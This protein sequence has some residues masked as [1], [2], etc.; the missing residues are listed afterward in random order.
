VLGVAGRLRDPALVACRAHL[1]VHWMVSNNDV[2]G[3]L[4]ENSAHTEGISA[5]HESKVTKD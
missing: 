2:Y 3:E 1:A 4:G 5:Q